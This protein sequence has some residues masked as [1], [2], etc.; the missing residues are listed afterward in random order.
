MFSD[1]LE[2]KENRAAME[3]RP[4]NHSETP[5]RGSNPCL[6]IPIKLLSSF[7]SLAIAIILDELFYVSFDALIETKL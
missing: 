2:L 5:K 1:D 4:Q 6:Y 7:L 3:F